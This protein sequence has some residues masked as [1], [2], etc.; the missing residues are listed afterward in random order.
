M[1]LSVG[2]TLT[3]HLYGSETRLFLIFSEICLVVHRLEMFDI[4][5]DILAFGAWPPKQPPRR[6]TVEW[7]WALPEHKPG[8]I[9]KCRTYPALTASMWRKHPFTGMRSNSE[10][11]V[12]ICHCGIAENRHPTGPQVSTIEKRHE[13]VKGL[14]G[15]SGPRD[16]YKRE[17]EGAET[18]RK[19]CSIIGVLGT[20]KLKCPKGNTK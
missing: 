16:T 13:E 15:A 10:K 18:I 7:F 9:L 20:F 4:S 11:D 17:R 6:F 8:P 19:G 2:L 5:M 12:L 14:G 1:S 3:K